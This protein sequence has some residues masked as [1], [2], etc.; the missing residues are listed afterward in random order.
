MKSKFLVTLLTSSK[1][2]YL[3]Q[4][5][6][7]VINQLP[8]NI[9]YDV[10]IIVNTLKDEYYEQVKITFNES[11]IVRTESNGYPGKGHNSCI[12]YFKNNKEYD[13][14]IPLD[15]DDFFYPFFFQN[16]EVYL[17]EQYNPDILFIPFSDILTLI[18]SPNELHYPFR[19]CYYYF[20][21]ETLDLM[22]SVYKCKLS[23]FKNKLEK[24]N[25]PGRI[26]F[27]S[28]KALEINFNYQE[29]LKWYDDLLPFLQIFEYMTLFPH[30][31]NI[32]FMEDYNL[33]LYNRLNEDSS[34]HN[35]LKDK[36]KN[37]ITENKNFQDAISNKFL[38]IR[39]W[40]I[41]NI[42]VLHNPNNKL[43]KQKFNF[44][45]NLIEQLNIK[46]MDNFQIDKNYIKAFNNHL[47]ENGYESIYKINK[48]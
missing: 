43:V 9:K 6:N 14:L 11:K 24:I 18:F 22:S 35:F 1:L 44:T 23:P 34:S 47:I 41:K 38:A 13:Y 30:K 27:I 31:L 25:T 36:E 40:D 29:N 33:Y 4:S 32:Y 48:N 46:S 16:L 39:N 5:Y 37:Y 10:V 8:T 42:K 3:K 45:K 15:G 7:S 26:I 28:R 17:Q 2:D 19:Q 21:V 20:N 12:E